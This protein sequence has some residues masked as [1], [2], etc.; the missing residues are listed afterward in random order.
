MQTELDVLRDIGDRLDAAEIPYMLTGSLALAYYAQPRMT[1]DIDLVVAMQ[2]SDV[3]G[4]VSALRTA[5][6]V[7]EDDAAAAAAS[8]GMFNVLHLDSMIKV[9]LVVRKDSEYRRTEFERRLY[10]QIAGVE[11]WIVSRE[12]LLLSKLVWG[13]ASGSELQ[14]RDVRALLQAGGVDMAYVSLWATRLGVDDLMRN[15]LP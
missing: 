12:D 9:D 6:Y 10:V 1:R 15:A 13:K 11:T 3:P 7:D 4:L 8:Q 2:S 14:Q 5:Y